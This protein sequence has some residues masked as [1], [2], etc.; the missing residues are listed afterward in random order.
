MVQWLS[1][2]WLFCSPLDPA[3]FLC[4]WHFSG[5]NYWSGVGCH[6]LLPG[7]P[8]PGMEPVSP[9]LQAD[10]LPLNHLGSNYSSIKKKIFFFLIAKP[11]AISDSSISGTH[12]GE[13][14][15]MGR[16]EVIPQAMRH[17][18]RYRAR[19]KWYHGTISGA[20]SHSER[21]QHGFQGGVI[22]SHRSF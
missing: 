21:L 17:W 1:Y 5:K 19:S 16:R 10:S 3:R 11:I 8:N 13:R 22:G 7:L 14:K 15:V 18:C 4:P 2:G 9:A 12:P 20:A 6:F